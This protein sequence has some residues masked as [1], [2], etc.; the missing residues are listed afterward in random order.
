MP[1]F[2]KG[3]RVTITNYDGE[4][5]GSYDFGQ[6]EARHLLVQL[7]GENQYAKELDIDCQDEMDGEDCQGERDVEDCL[8][9]IWKAAVASIEANPG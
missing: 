6:H 5:Y 9:D 3:L 8:S 7:D 1:D 2:K 4:V